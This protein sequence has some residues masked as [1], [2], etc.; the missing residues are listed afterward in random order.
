MTSASLSPCAG[1]VAPEVSSHAAILAWTHS[2]LE[3]PTFT[4]VWQASFRAL[5]LSF[6]LGT[7]QPRRHHD[8]ECFTSRPALGSSRQVRF[9]P[10]VS[11]ALGLDADWTLQS[12]DI[13][14]ASL[15]A[16]TDKPWS[17]KRIRTP[18]SHRNADER[19]FPLRHLPNG[20]QATDAPQD[21]PVGPFL[22]EAPQSIQDLFQALMEEDFIDGE[23]LNEPVL[24]RSWYVH[25]RRVPEWNVPRS[26][27]LQGHWRFWAADILDG[28]R[29]QL[30]PDEDVALAVVFPNPPRNNVMQPIVFDIIVIQGLDLPRRACLATVLRFQDPQQRAE[31]SLAISL[32]HFTSAKYVA[33]RAHLVQDCILQDCTVRQG[34][35]ILEWSDAPTHDARDGQSFIIRRLPGTAG[36]S[37]S[38]HQAGLPSTSD[39]PAAHALDVHEE[40]PH[41]VEAAQDLD[42]DSNVS[43]ASTVD[44]QSVFVYRLAAQTTFGHADWSSH[45]A[46]VASVARIAEVPLAE[47]VTV[48]SMQCQLPDQPPNVLAVILQHVQDIPP[49]SM[50]CLIIIDVE[51]HMHSLPG[52]LPVAPHSTRQVHRVYPFLRRA[53]I[54]QLTRV[55]AYCEW[56][57]NSCLVYHNGR[58]WPIL[59]LAPRHLQH[60]AFLKVII[61]PP[62]DGHGNTA[63]AVQVA[64]EA[65]DLFDFPMASQVIP[66]LLLA[67]QP[68]EPA[69]PPPGNFYVRHW[70]YPG[71]R[72]HKNGEEHEFDDFPVSERS[73]RPTQIE[74]PAMDWSGNWMQQLVQ[75]MRAEGEEEIVDGPT[76]LYLQ[77]WFIH[78]ESHTVCRHP[79]PV[80]ITNEIISW[81]YDLRQAWTDMLEHGGAVRFHVVQ[82]TPMRAPLQSYAGHV[83][84]EQAPLNGRAAVVVST[85]LESLQ[86]NALMQFARSL[87]RFVTADD[88]I[89]ES[90]L[91]PHCTVRP[92]S[93]W[94]GPRQ[95]NIAIATELS[96]GN[97]IRIHVKPMPYEAPVQV[98]PPIVYDNVD[99]VSMI[100]ATSLQPT[101]L[102]RQHHSDH[103][104]RQTIQECRDHAARDP[105]PPPHE[106][107][108]P[109][110]I[111]QLLHAWRLWQ[112]Q[113]GDQA[114]GMFTVA[115]WYSNHVTDRRS[116]EYR[117]VRLGGDFTSWRRRLT[118]IWSDRV[119]AD[120]PVDIAIVEPTPHDGNG[121]NAAHVVLVQQALPG[122]YTMILSVVDLWG[123]PW[124]PRLL[125][126]LIP[127]GADHVQIINAAGVL[128]QCPPFAPGTACSVW[129]GD[130]RI[131]DYLDDVLRHGISFHVMV[132]MIHEPLALLTS[133]T[134]RGTASSDEINLLQTRVVAMQ[135][136]LATALSLRIDCDQP[137]NLKMET[138][139]EPGDKRDPPHTLV[140]NDLIPYGATLIRTPCQKVEF[141][142]NQLMT[143]DLGPIQPFASVVNWHQQTQLARRHT[144]DWEG[145]LPRRIWF[146]TDGA[147]SFAQD[148]GVRHASAS[149]VM[150]LETDWG[151]QFGGFRTCHVPLPA[152]APLAEHAAIH[153]ATLWSIQILEWCAWTFGTSC[154]PL[155]FAFDCLAAGAAAQGTWLC[156][157]HASLHRRTRALQ[158]WLH[159][160]FQC[161]TDFV[162]VPSHR[163][164]PWNEAADAACWAAMHGWIPA[165]DFD[166]L[167]QEQIVP[168]DDVIEWL[169]FWQNARDG[170]IEYPR[171]CDG[172]FH[173][174]IEHRDAPAVDASE[175]TFAKFHDSHQ[176]GPRTTCSIALRA[177][178][179]NVLT[180]YPNKV[181]KGGFVS[182][183]HEALMKSFR[184]QG[185]QIAGIQETRSKL[186]GHHE[187]EFYHVLSAPATQKGHSGVQIW[188]A[189]QVAH[190]GGVIHVRTS[191]MRILHQS[192]RKLIVRLSADGLRLLLVAGHVPCMPDEAAAQKWWH[193]ALQGLPATY[194]S[195]PRLMLVDANARVGSLT[196]QAIGPHQASDEN[197]HGEM[198][199]QWL[200]DHHMFAPQTMADHHVGDAPTF[201]HARGAEGR[202]DYILVDECLRHPNLRT[203]VLDI[204]LA[205]QRPDHFVVAADLPISFW[206]FDRNPRKNPCQVQCLTASARV[207][208]VVAWS[209]DVHSHAVRIHQW[210]QHCQPRKPRLPRKRHLQEATWHLIQ[211]KAYHWKRARQ[212]RQCLRMTFLRSIFDGWRCVHSSNSAPPSSKWLRQCHFDL[213]WHLHCHRQLCPSV[214][215][216]VRQDDNEYYQ[217]FAQSHSMNPCLPFGKL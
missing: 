104:V 149:A 197:A 124:Y 196:S 69:N 171:I 93:V 85:L 8:A 56:V 72:R 82:P 77:T 100:H 139:L 203:F 142:A 117:T 202:I 108:Q 53:N 211:C 90:E 168:F 62:P 167:C 27:E 64:R 118:N 67:D 184:D 37:S 212:I 86:G 166:R 146:Y 44:R 131:D 190:P 155:V 164:D 76:Y 61:P 141:F 22:H 88:V 165:F 36:A 40:E 98:P 154:I 215:Q 120:Q 176:D 170:K 188:I 116:D 179:A 54:L 12:F 59:E 183:R 204:D 94:I 115:V 60:G 33:A 91:V 216:R 31:R 18:R 32:P 96:S 147:S 109:I 17:G 3:E 99:E 201:A 80:R 208:P 38:T 206:Q 110:A 138:K 127:D 47:V 161:S 30:F 163:G 83:L 182:A 177:A 102:I 198:M 78:H 45:Q 51:L 68:D 174:A 178:T 193:Q 145:T 84:L 19:I 191:H 89:Q 159:C 81:S 126:D 113:Q 173:F 5:C 169:W 209:E 28:W 23:E 137:Q 46:M 181:E 112:D 140:L 87:P 143:M 21:Q 13:S 210:L 135:R 105:P 34:R 122:I 213:A 39:A 151:C 150:I 144:A 136:R 42:Y 186:T 75:L 71:M 73:R 158:H 194:Q 2:V 172:A 52:A 106:E 107:D 156:Q 10:N 114:D 134:H 15:S 14:E 214:M 101:C 133:P 153:L 129:H 7:L 200:I 111:Q 95:L 55:D 92:C 217:K 35:V 48:H 43:M 26:Q 207:P 187:T 65:A 24:L 189:K 123:D 180:L 57:Q 66:G 152:T 58:G 119:L 128:T 132:D 121:Q 20:G 1:H 79:R 157:H 185:I 29:D 160:R 70:K 103:E 125:C 74:L 192:A 6:D 11:I 148:D 63:H 16:W 50:E 97:G 130:R 195:W 41:Q 199:H 25:H 205:V 162:H 4:S 49:A 175:H 9:N